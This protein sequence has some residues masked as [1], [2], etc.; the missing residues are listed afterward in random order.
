MGVGTWELCRQQNQL[1]LKSF[2]CGVIR[3]REEPT[4]DLGNRE[5]GGYEAL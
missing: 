3:E 5:Q 2:G 1:F 4:S